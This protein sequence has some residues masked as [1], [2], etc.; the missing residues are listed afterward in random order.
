LK[1]CLGDTENEAAEYILIREL[2]K[3]MRGCYHKRGTPSG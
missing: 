3:M 2:D 1:G